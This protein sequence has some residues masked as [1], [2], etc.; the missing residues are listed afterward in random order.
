MWL[1]L[2]ILHTAAAFSSRDLGTLARGSA[3]ERWWAY[4]RLSDLLARDPEAY[5]AAAATVPRSLLPNVENV[6]IGEEVANTTFTE[7]VFERL[8]L[9]LTRERYAVHSPIAY[10]SPQPGIRGLL[11]EMKALAFSDRGDP[12]TQR[13]VVVQVLRDLATP[14]LPPFFRFFVAGVPWANGTTPFWAPYVTS[15]VAPLVFSYLVGPS[16][17]NRRSDGMRGGL[18]VTK[19]K[20]LQ[21][22]GCKGL[23]LHQC[24]LPAEQLFKDDFNL[25]LYVKPNFDTQECQWS[26]G[27][28][29][30]PPEQDPTWP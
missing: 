20:F 2:I 13:E 10:R 8:L 21:E 17:V 19:C 30:P 12:D 24:K 14:A 1:Q 15:L 23:C 29:P 3:I 6:P 27:M 7:N 22:S 16:T 26:W 11:E 18:V 28:S 4:T 5:V 9:W 25:D